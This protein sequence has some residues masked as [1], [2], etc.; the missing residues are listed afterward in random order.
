MEKS[1]RQLAV[2]TL[3]AAGLC[4][5]MPSA[6]SIWVDEAH[7]LRYVAQPTFGGWLRELRSD[8]FSEALMPL[9]MLIAWIGGKLWGLSEWGLR[10][11]NLPWTLLGV[12]VFA[13]LGRRWNVPW[14][15]LAFALQPFVWYYTNEARPYALQ[16]G[17]GA[18]LLAGLADALRAGALHRGTLA[19]LVLAGCALIATTLFG[20]LTVG[21][22][23][24]VLGW[25]ARRHRWRL[26]AGG[27]WLLGGGF[28]WALALGAYYVNLVLGG[29]KGAKLWSVGFSNLLFVAYEFLG[30]AGLGP[31]RDA[32]REAARAGGLG[33]VWSTISPHALLLAL[34]G[35]LLVLVIWG[36]WRASRRDERL[37]VGSLAFVLI[38]VSGA[39]VLLALLAKFPFWGRH[40]APVFPFFC[41][42]LVIGLRENVERLPR[43]LA[44]SA[45]LALAALTAASSAQLRLS[46]RHEKD[47]YR[48]AA[49]L[50]GAALARGEL[51]WWSAD[52]RAAEYYR[53]PVTMDP[54]ARSAALL[55]YATDV[56]TLRT[57]TPPALVV[58]SKPDIYDTHA[59]LATLLAERGYRPRQELKAF[60]LWS[61]P[62]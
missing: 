18:L 47:D 15:P 60:K 19:L 29:A 45:V 43:A 37:L 59:A 23:G 56:E 13:F 28:L 54:A 57:F 22:V 55:V 42:L 46:P 33:A 52:P 49:A 17:L 14:A 35:V 16:I 6:Q 48:Q 31:G 58:A 3:L 32:L 25:V 39:M 10:A 51:V 36:I 7:Q 4:L 53:L 2:C 41:A 50:A 20:V 5:L 11:A 44:F 30:F 61:P 1:D 27:A 12:G 26:P 40:L 38:C 21:A 9:A 34:L 62:H 8:A 24:L